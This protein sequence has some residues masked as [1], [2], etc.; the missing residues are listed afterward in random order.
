MRREEY[1]S[2]LQP[3]IQRQPVFRNSFQILSFDFLSDFRKTSI[4]L[5]TAGRRSS[6]ISANDKRLYARRIVNFAVISRL[7]SAWM[8]SSS[9]CVSFILSK[10]HPPCRPIMEI[11]ERLE[12]KESDE[13]MSDYIMNEPPHMMDECSLLLD[14]EILNASMEAIF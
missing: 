2:L 1:R 3:E 11:E 9:S 13:R 10:I 6:C 14:L 7:F 12:R 8:I 4:V 5:R